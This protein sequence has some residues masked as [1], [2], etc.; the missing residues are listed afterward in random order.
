MKQQDMK[1]QDIKQQDMKQQDMKKQDMKQQD[2]KQQHTNNTN[3][4]Y[5]PQNSSK[6][7]PYETVSESVHK[8]ANFLPTSKNQPFS[9]PKSN[10]VGPWP[11]GRNTD[12]YLYYTKF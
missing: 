3:Y 9:Y 6:S 4:N 5:N 11:L 8:T 12:D 10:S 1:Q 2:M 7:N